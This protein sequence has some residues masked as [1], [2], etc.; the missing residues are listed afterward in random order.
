MLFS[1]RPLLSLLLAAVLAVTSVTTAVARMAAH[2]HYSV[3]ICSLEGVVQITLDA[4]GNPVQPMHP[5]PDCLVVGF[6]DLP[7]AIVAPAAPLT[8]ARLVVVLTAAVAQP[9]QV[10]APMARGPPFPV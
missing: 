9:A 1:L 2:G 10:F 5:C 3:V 8:L 6:A 7:Q 4:Q